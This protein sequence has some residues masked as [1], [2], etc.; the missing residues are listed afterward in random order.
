EMVFRSLKPGDDLKP[1]S[2]EI[3]LT[4]HG[5]ATALAESPRNPD[6]LWA[7]TDDGGLWVTRD[8]GAK[9]TRVDEKVGLPGPRWVSTIEA[10]RFAD[11]RA[12]VA[13]DAHRSNDDKPYIYVTE[14]YGETWKPLMANLPAFGSSRCL[15]E[16]VQNANLLFCGT[17]FAV[18][19]SINRGGYWT[20][21]NNN[22]PTVAVH[23]LAIH[24]TAGEMVAATHGRSLWVVDVTALR[25]MTPETVKAPAHLYAPPAA[26]RWRSE[27]DVGSGIGNGAKKFHG[28]NPPRGVAIYYSLG[29]K[30]EKIN[31]KVLDYAGK[32][33]RDL[34]TH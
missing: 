4:K 32:T 30:A 26:T 19:A 7:G 20:K 23:E 15:R 8:G 31:L 16:D 27:P 2:P 24:P 11:G 9:W 1:V 21:I 34:T 18:Y 22:L 33:V 5:S 14:N 17:E 12:Y 6:I 25:Q 3:T 28:Q 13:F 10:S 29:K